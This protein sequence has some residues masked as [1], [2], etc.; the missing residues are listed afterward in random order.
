M[1]AG[2]PL[3]I[4]LGA[5]LKFFK[6]E[7]VSWHDNEKTML[8][9]WAVPGILISAIRHFGQSGYILFMLPIITIYSPPLLNDALL[10]YRARFPVEKQAPIRRLFNLFVGMILVSNCIIFLAGGY[11]TIHTQDQRWQSVA[12][13]QKEYAAEST[14]ILTDFNAV[15]GYRH[16]SYYFPEYETYGL[17][18][19]TI[20]PPISIQD[21]RQRNLGWAF[22]SQFREDNFDLRKD[23]HPIQKVLNLQP[24]TIGFLVTGEGIINAFQNSNEEY[25]MEEFR[26]DEIGDWIIY[27]EVPADFTQLVFENG[28]FRI[29]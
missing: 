8:F 15:T 4:I 7:S 3:F 5:W 23:A 29:H 18:S 28:Y 10:A 24:D 27:V 22:L 13:I 21:S 14:I 19:A 20:D 16:M 26:I 17:I 12:A 11:L 9:L 2:I 25:G 1:E 6:T